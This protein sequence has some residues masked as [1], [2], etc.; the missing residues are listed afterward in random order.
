MRIAIAAGLGIAA[1]AASASIVLS[2]ADPRRAAPPASVAAPAP[3]EDPI[4]VEVLRPRPIDADEPAQL[5]TARSLGTAPPETRDARL[6]VR[7]TDADTGA[8]VAM[9]VRLWRLGVTEDDRWTGGDVD[10]ETIQVAE[11]G[12]S[13]RDLVPGRYRLCCDAQREG[14]PDPPEFEVR[15]GDNEFKAA[16]LLARTVPLWLRVVD[17]E[18]RAIE[19]GSVRGLG[20]CNHRRSRSRPPWARHRAEKL[21]DGGF[22]FPG[23]SGGGVGC[24]MRSPSAAAALAAP[25]GFAVGLWTEPRR[26]GRSSSGTQFEFD[27]RSAVRVGAG[28][29]EGDTGTF[30]APSLPIERLLEGLTLEDG[31]SPLDRGATVEAQAAAIPIREGDPADAWRSVPIRVKVTLAGYRTLELDRWL[32]G[33]EPE[34]RRMMRRAGSDTE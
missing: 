9:E 13:T 5:P 10:L 32:D 23:S 14:A 31:G 29:R 8:P 28:W 3:A 20:A 1:T 2:P 17:E 30:I 33:R 7:L 22:R 34:G 25:E 21:P 19:S 27:G 11:G 12:G 24:S 15:S 26:N 18:G 4:E 6:T 16:V